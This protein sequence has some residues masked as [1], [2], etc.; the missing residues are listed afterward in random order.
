M[1]FKDEFRLSC[2]AVI[3]NQQ[4]QVLLVR[5]TYGSCGWGLPGGALEPGE[6][7]HQALDRECKEELGIQVQINYLSGVYFHSAFNSQAFIFSCEVFDDAGIVLSCEHSAY[8]YSPVDELSE[9]QQTRINDCLNF[10]GYVK[11]A[12][13]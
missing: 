2:H 10:S 9:I 4:Q 7:I 6:T 13:F 12:A 1:A 5:A 11:S 3:F 8:K